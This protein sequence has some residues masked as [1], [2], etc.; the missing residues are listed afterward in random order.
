MSNGKKLA[1][2]LIGIAIKCSGCTIAVKMKLRDKLL[3]TNV[4]VVL[5]ILL[6]GGG[7]LYYFTS[8]ITE[9]NIRSELNH[10]V[11]LIFDSVQS[12]IQVS[13]R[14]HLRT[15]AE[16][17]KKVFQIQY[18]KVLKGKL[19]Y[20]QAYAEIRN[21]LRQKE[22]I[23]IGNS[24][25]L[26]T[27]DL[28]G[29]VRIHPHLSP[30]TDLS[31]YPFMQ[32]ALKN[33]DGF[34]EY[35][36]QNKG[37]TNL[38]R[39]ATA[40]VTF[41]PWG[42]MIWASSYKDE[43]ASLI[44]IEDFR[45]KLERMRVGKSGY[46]CIVDVLG[47]AIIHPKFM[48]KNI[49]YLKDQKGEFFIQK[50]M[51]RKNGRIRYSFRNPDESKFQ[52]KISHFRFIPGLNWYVISTA[53]AREIYEP[54]RRITIIIVLTIFGTLTL[55]GVTIAWVSSKITEPLNHLSA[56]M[57]KISEGDMTT[58]L[59]YTG[60]D[61][62]SQISK[63][64]NLMSEKLHENFKQV[65]AQ[66]MEIQ[67]Y[68][69][70][71]EKVLN[72][73][74]RNLN[75]ALEDIRKKNE[76]MMQAIEASQ[77]GNSDFTSES[78]VFPGI[79]SNDL[80]RQ[81]EL[82]SRKLQGNQY[83]FFPLSEYRFAFLVLDSSS[84]KAVAALLNNIAR[85][86]FA[87]YASYALPVEEIAKRIN[88]D[89]LEITAD[90]E[91]YLTAY[92]GIIDMERGTL[93]ITNSGLKSALLY[94]SNSHNVLQLDSEGFILG[95]TRDI[96]F[97]STRVHLS[98]GDKL[99]VTSNIIKTRN[100]KGEIYG[101]NRLINFLESHNSLSARNFVDALIINVNHYAEDTKNE[102]NQVIFYLHFKNRAKAFNA[103]SQNVSIET[104]E[105]FRNFDHVTHSH[106]EDWDEMIKLYKQAKHMLHSSRYSDTLDL[107]QNIPE[108]WNEDLRVQEIMLE[109][110]YRS[111]DL[112]KTRELFN[113]FAMHEESFSQ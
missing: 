49:T 82:G 79:Q 87:T 31:I 36:W 42:E 110:Q 89:L 11:N 12:S 57:K 91:Y 45:Q 103:V 51:Q 46:V 101:Q 65:Q 69:E 9:K 7:V 58:R 56:S 107:L 76:K 4:S 47:N 74:T 86:A 48:N 113:R 97:D 5:I 41:E 14:H 71:L 100:K 50:I 81:I 80:E 60:N 53:Y 102:D 54:L 90:H 23:R 75:H 40:F 6:L 10:T 105:I 33:K 106:H 85:I 18:K 96:Y 109:S 55:L 3:Y 8:K 61:E 38:R 63:S 67:K 22:K 94:R 52:E 73:R 28:N 78:F 99:L 68:N 37:E 13:I 25:Y 20:K 83:D 93:Q 88:N 17:N 111:G 32:K 66:K 77:N 27:T 84:R 98:P 29:R 95:I 62:F 21:L 1:F 2:L 59:I 15:I 70:E 104:R 44:S 35:S 43:F 16:Q 108:H 112:D 30:G 26:F 19:A 34:V 39:K 24:G 92:L 64:F 72:D